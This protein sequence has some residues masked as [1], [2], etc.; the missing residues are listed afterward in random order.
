LVVAGEH[1][2]ITPTVSVK[3]S[4]PLRQKRRDRPFRAGG[5][6]QPGA[7][8]FCCP[9]LRVGGVAW[10]GGR[11]VLKKQRR[12]GGAPRRWVVGPP[13]LEPGTK[14]LCLPLRLSPPTD[15]CSWSGLCLHR[16]LLGRCPRVQSLH[17]PQRVGA[18]LGVGVGSRR[19]AGSVRRLY[20]G[21]T[22]G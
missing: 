16:G 10:G 9:R 3:Y 15:R 5:P 17:L 7:H 1:G 14:G 8:W 11:L 21:A 4:T 19:T 20:G 6:H 13:G 12:Q 22:P 2:E 18:W